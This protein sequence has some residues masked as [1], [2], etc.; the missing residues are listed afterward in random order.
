MKQTNYVNYAKLFS[1][2]F[3]KTISKKEFAETLAQNEPERA[4]K[5]FKIL[6]D[7]FPEITGNS[8][9]APIEALLSGL[10]ENNE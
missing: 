10:A 7:T 4:A 5:I 8:A 1:S 3:L 2:R 9:A 6:A